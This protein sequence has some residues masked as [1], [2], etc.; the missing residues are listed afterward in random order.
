M[1]NED[2]RRAE[3]ALL[4]GGIAP[5]FA[6]RTIRELQDHFADIREALIR[7]G[8]PEEEAERGAA[9]RV[10]DLQAIVR[11]CLSR[12]ELKSF[13][14][15][16]PKTFFL[17]GPLL[18]QVLAVVFL[19]VLLVMIIE[20]GP[21]RPASFWWFLPAAKTLGFLYMYALPV[22]IAAMLLL[23]GGARRLP[24]GLI[25]A[26]VLLTACLGSMMSINF[27]LPRMEGEPGSVSGILTLLGF[28]PGPNVFIV[29][30]FL[31]SLL[32]IV[33]TV[34]VALA[35]WRWRLSRASSHPLH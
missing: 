31:K 35:L 2:L 28:M 5:R 24:P 21:V 15:R 29:S 19:F 33:I 10:G 25:A 13:I 23:S 22:L 17:L 11:E 7:E 1:F 20:V 12:R 8:V 16:Y 3:A 9:E 30:V 34:L 18:A 27:T 6:R 32:R 4:R 26:G 14:S